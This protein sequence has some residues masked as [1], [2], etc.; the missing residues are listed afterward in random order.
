MS[1]MK[2]LLRKIFDMWVDIREGV[3]ITLAALKE[4]YGEEAYAYDNY[5]VI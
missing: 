3:A 2:R 1:T 4:I 5:V